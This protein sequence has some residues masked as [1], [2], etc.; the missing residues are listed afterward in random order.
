MLLV[1]AT[2]PVAGSLMWGTRV[3]AALNV[4]GLISGVEGAWHGSD[5]IGFDTAVWKTGVY[6]SLVLATTWGGEGGGGG[7]GVRLHQC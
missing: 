3:L 1:Y 6:L 5:A 7:E 2:A 4:Q